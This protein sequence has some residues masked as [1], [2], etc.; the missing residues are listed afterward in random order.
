MFFQALSF[1]LKTVTVSPNGRV[2]FYNNQDQLVLG[3]KQTS[4]FQLHYSEKFLY[5]WLEG[6]RPHFSPDGQNMTMAYGSLYK[7]TV[8]ALEDI[9]G[10]PFTAITDTVNYDLAEYDAKQ[11]EVFEWMQE[12]VLQGCCGGGS[13]SSSVAFYD[14]FDSFPVTGTVDVLYVD[15]ETPA[16]YLWDGSTYV[17]FGGAG[18]FVPYTGATGDVDLGAHGLITDFVRYNT[19]PVSTLQEGQTQWNDDDGTLDVRLKGDNVTLQVGQEQVARVVNKVGSNLLEANYS[20]VRSRLVSEGGASGQRL[21]VVL[22]QADTVNNCSTTLG[23][24][25]EDINNNAEGF[26]TTSGIVRGIN[27]TGSLQG[28]TWADGDVLYLSPSVA[29]G[30]TNVQPTTPDYIV[31]MGYVVY[32]HGTQGKIYVTVQNEYRLNEFATLYWPL[33]GN[34]GGPN[35]V[36]GNIDVDPAVA[37]FQLSQTVGTWNG[38]FQIESGGQIRMALDSPSIN[39]YVSVSNSGVNSN[40]TDGTN[41]SAFGLN[42]A[43]AQ[44]SSSNETENTRIDV[45]PT[46]A[47]ITSNYATFEGLKYA[48]NYSA[49]F[50]L[51]SLID[52]E[53]MKSRIWTKAGTPTTTDDINA[54]Y[55]VG[56]LIWDTTNS[57]LYKCTNNTAGAATWDEA[58]QSNVTLYDTIRLG[59]IVPSSSTRYACVGV[60]GLS[61]SVV[62]NI[63]PPELHTDFR[64]VLGAAQPASGTLVVER[65]FTDY[66]G[67]LLHTD[68]LTI[69]AGSGVGEYI[70]TGATYDASGGANMRFVIT[71]N[72]TVN[73]AFIQGIENQYQ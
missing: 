46:T 63:A 48:D 20:A 69:P 40:V 65:V 67:T 38:Y 25:T 37:G 22:A 53:V 23:L 16:L 28:E 18:S 31:I 24:V 13:G 51:R 5:V 49:N 21:A 47:T 36:T 68:T 6:A 35:Y 30:L 61:S 44:M 71:N 32:A 9:D 64:I 10:K 73:S 4:D 59:T 39:G 57:I 2:L 70:F 15:K 41:S 1:D 12:V 17:G 58:I 55:L 56:S 60:T 8:F 11:L 43:N 26:V 7:M 33:A 54:E 29:G 45:A 50:T 66:S 42:P 62:L 19:T 3:I 72:A 14:D 27:T 52:Q 34:V